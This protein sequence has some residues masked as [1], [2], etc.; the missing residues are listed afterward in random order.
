MTLEG[1]L[2]ADYSPSYPIAGNL[3][4]VDSTYETFDE[5]LVEALRAGSEDAYESLIQRFQHPVYNLICRLLDDSSEAP[6]VMQEVFLKVFRKIGAFRGQSSLKT[7]I[8]RIAV[9]EAYNQ[10]RFFSRHRKQEVGLERTDDI[11]VNYREI[12]PDQCRSPFEIVAGLEAQ[13]MVSEAL[14]DINPSFRAAV[15]L[16]DIEEL[17]YEEVAEVLQVNLGT[18]KSRILRG[19]E[20]LGKRIASRLEKADSGKLM[21]SHVGGLRGGA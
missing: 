20:A 19:R 3:D 6:D 21:P 16:R 2:V 13:E 4:G 9:N 11:G 18:V 12:L 14:K 15:V 8:Y 5:Q 7:W 17:S 1:F 10:R